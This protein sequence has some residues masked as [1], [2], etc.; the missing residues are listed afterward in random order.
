MSI[1]ELL[2]SSFEPRLGQ[3]S[4]GWLYYLLMYQ[5]TVNPRQSSCLKLIA[6][7]G[8]AQAVIHLFHPRCRLICSGPINSASIIIDFMDSKAD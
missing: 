2:L 5:L 7:S 1:H 8:L 3:Q 6:H 4:K